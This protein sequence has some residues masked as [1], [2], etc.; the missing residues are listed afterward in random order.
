MVIGTDV[1]AGQEVKWYAGGDQQ[2]DEITVDAADVSNGYV[3]LT[4][5]AEYGSV[6]ITVNG[7]VTAC[8]ELQAD[9]STPA[10]ETSGTETISYTGIVLSDTVV[11][12]YLNI[13][14]TPLQQ[15]AACADVKTGISVDTKEAAIHGQ[16]NKIKTIGAISQEAE[17]EEFHYNQTF[18]AMCLGDQVSNS[19][20]T[21]MDKLSTKYRG[22]KKFGGLVGKRFSAAGAVLYKWFLF[23]AQATGVD[24]EFP[25]ED[26]YK[27]SM[28][29]QIDDYLETDLEV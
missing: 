20:A 14:D 4:K 8:T 6:F 17:L 18:I 3:D 10:T 11:A 22:V 29:F 16:S 9:G 13:E 12:Y 1:P 24:K 7:V 19:P 23:G 25:T 2:T 27:D 21:G 26:F 15:I 5:K 28:K